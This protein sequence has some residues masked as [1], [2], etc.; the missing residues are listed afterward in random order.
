MARVRL[1]DDELFE[2]FNEGMK[3]LLTSAKDITKMK[4]HNKYYGKGPSLDK[5]I[6]E[7]YEYM[8]SYL[9]DM[10]YSEF[11]IIRKL[12]TVDSTV[13]ANTLPS[14]MKINLSSVLLKVCKDYV[15]SCLSIPPVVFVQDICSNLLY[16][17]NNLEYNMIKNINK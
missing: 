5:T 15:M 17:I 1:G 16:D 7:I 3:E 6:D 4:L 12:Y 9:D 8:L 13:E 14:F 2:K 11:S 10:P